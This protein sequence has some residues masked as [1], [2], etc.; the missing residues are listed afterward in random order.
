MLGSSRRGLSPIDDASAPGSKL[1]WLVMVG[2]GMFCIVA[3]Y[4]LNRRASG[5]VADKA[6]A[7][8]ETQPRA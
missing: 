2:G 1:W 3:A 4:A 6:G 7:L 5:R 8:D